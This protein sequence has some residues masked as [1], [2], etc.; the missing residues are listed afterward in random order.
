M[1]IN[2]E[3]YQFLGGLVLGLLSGVGIGMYI[4]YQVHDFCDRRKDEE[5]I[6]MDGFDKGMFV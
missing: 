4:A 2:W 1:N 6:R 3:I 5:S